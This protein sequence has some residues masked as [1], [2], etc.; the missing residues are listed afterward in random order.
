M[1]SWPT[2][3]VSMPC[4]QVDRPSI[5]LGLLKAIG[6]AHGF[7]VRTLHAGLDFAVR[8]GLDY[9]QLLAEHRGRQIGDWLF[10]AEAFGDAAPDPHG[11]LLQEL[12]A[13][14]SYVDES[15]ELARKR[16]LATR[17][18][19]RFFLLQLLLLLRLTQVGVDTAVVLAFVL[20]QVEDLK[21][22]VVLAFGLEL[23]L[24]ADH[25]LTGGVDGEL[26]QVGDDPFTA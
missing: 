5:Q 17:E 15:V 18:Q 19:D 8:I 6:E 14:L 11:D 12:G 23:A 21:G 9:Y 3:I 20:A 4:Q 2:V 24:H 1:T 25:A 16:L 13:E 26:A 7:P 10:S 22:A